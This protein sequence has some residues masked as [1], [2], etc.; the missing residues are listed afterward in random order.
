MV[1]I[2][3]RI[4]QL[5]VGPNQKSGVDNELVT[6]GEERAKASGSPPGELNRTKRL[7]GVN[8]PVSYNP[9]KA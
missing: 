8:L 5:T 3:T 2:K 7:I 9:S 6:E 4:P 1:G